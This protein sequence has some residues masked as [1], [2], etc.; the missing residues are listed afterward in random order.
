MKIHKALEGVNRIFLDTAPIIY[1]VEAHVDFGARSQAIFVAMDEH[2]IQGIVSPVTLAECLILPI[3]LQQPD[4]QANFQDLLLGS[5]GISLVNIDATIGAQAADLRV[6]YGFKLPDALQ[7]ATA[8]A[9]NCDAFL[10][11]DRMLARVTELRVLV[12]ADLEV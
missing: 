3:R 10:T 9:S 6:R 2:E 5:D 7:V 4:I 1:L 11:N 12:L 8:L